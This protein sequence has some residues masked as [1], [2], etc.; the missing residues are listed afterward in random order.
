VKLRSLFVVALPILGT[1]IAIFAPA[2]VQISYVTSTLLVLLTSQILRNAT[3]RR[4]LG[5]APIVRPNDVA[6][7]PAP[8]QGTITVAAR[9]RAENKPHNVVANLSMLEKLKP[10]NIRTQYDELVKST[11]EFV[12]GVIP[13]A[14]KEVQSKKDKKAKEQVSAHEKM[15]RRQVDAQRATFYESQKAKRKQR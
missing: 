1:A 4:K 11:T 5:L 7:A 9:V 8:Y 15:R 3:A 10:K 14:S 12:G 13:Q 6:A 2:T